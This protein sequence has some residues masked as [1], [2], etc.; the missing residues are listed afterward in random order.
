[1]H[2]YIVNKR[3][4]V[5]PTNDNAS[6]HGGRKALWFAAGIVLTLG[7]WLLVLRIIA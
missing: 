5:R 1:V 6:P 3:V 2:C 4:P 7:A